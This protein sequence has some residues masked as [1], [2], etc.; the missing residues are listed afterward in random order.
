MAR[1]NRQGPRGDPD[2]FVDT[3]AE[4]AGQDDRP[5]PGNHH[6]DEEP[7]VGPAS[8]KIG[9]VAPRVSK[10]AI[11][12]YAGPVRPWGFRSSTMA[13]A[14]G[15]RWGLSEFFLCR[16][17]RALSASQPMQGAAGKR[18]ASPQTAAYGSPTVRRMS[19]GVAPAARSSRS[20]VA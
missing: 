20:P 16:Q 18:S 19:A 13:E 10:R 1:G 4:P 9:V 12:A 11:T 7:A 3:D 6:C 2:R 5:Y 17:A 8:M 15:L 14:G